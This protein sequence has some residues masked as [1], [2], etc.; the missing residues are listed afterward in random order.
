MMH[1]Y[2]QAQPK[3]VQDALYENVDDAQ[4]VARNRFV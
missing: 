4:S 1:S 3:W 2:G